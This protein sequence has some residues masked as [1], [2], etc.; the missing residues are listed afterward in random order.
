M[1]KPHNN[2]QDGQQERAVQVSIKM[3]TELKASFVEYC[4][5]MRV[6]QGLIIGRLVE[7]FL[8]QPEEIQMLIQNVR[9]PVS[10]IPPKRVP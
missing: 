9:H 5:P 1:P 8:A 7:W 4:R 10:D 3:A 6:Q 2:K